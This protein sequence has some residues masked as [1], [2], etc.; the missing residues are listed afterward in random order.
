MATKIEPQNITLY[1]GQIQQFKLVSLGTHLPAWR[2]FGA[3]ATQNAD[4]SLSWVSGATLAGGGL[5]AL[6]DSGGTFSVTLTNDNFPG[7]G[8][9]GKL[10]FTALDTPN[11]YCLIEWNNSGVLTLKTKAPDYFTWYGPSGSVGLYG[12]AVTNGVE[13]SQTAPAGFTAINFNVG[14]TVT[15]DISAAGIRIIGMGSGSI[16][17]TPVSHATLGGTWLP[18]IAYSQS[19][20]LPAISSTPKLSPP[21]LTGDWAPKF[22]LGWSMD[23]AG[24][25]STTLSTNTNSVNNLT[26]NAGAFPGTYKLTVDQENA[27]GQGLDDIAATVTVPEFVVAS[28]AQIGMKK[29]EKRTIATSYDGKIEVTRTKTGGTFDGTTYTAPNA[30]GTYT[31]TFTAAGQVRTV[32]VTVSPALTPEYEIVYPG[33]VLPLTTD[34][35]GT[36]AW[37]LSAGGGALSTNS[38]TTSTWTV[39]QSQ[40]LP[41]TITLT[42]GSDTITRTYQVLDKFPYYPSEDWN[43]TRNKKTVGVTLEGGRT[44]SH[45]KSPNGL[46]GETFSFEYR[47]REIDEFEAVKTFWDKYYPDGLFMVE[48]PIRAKRYAAQFAGDLTHRMDG[49]GLIAYS[50][51][52]RVPSTATAAGNT[53][54]SAVSTGTAVSNIVNVT[55]NISGLTA[56]TGDVTASGTGSVAATLANSGVTAGNYTNASITVDGKGRVT[57][58][59]N[60]AG[61]PFAD[62]TDLIKNSADNTKLLRLSAANVTT[63]TTRTLTAQNASYT[64]AGL[65]T[66]QAFT[67]LNKFN[68]GLWA[69]NGNDNGVTIGY[70]TGIGNTASDAVRIGAFANGGA[71]TTNAQGVHVGRHSGFNQV[72]GDNSITIGH[73]ANQYGTGSS[74]SSVL[75]G[76]YAGR[77]PSQ[78]ANFY[79]FSSVMIGN[80][81][82]LNA[83]NS[84]TSVKIGA[85]AGRDATNS[86]GA[87]LIGANAGDGATN[88][89]NSVIIGNYAGRLATSAVNSV[90]IGNEAG[91]T[92][93]RNNS[94]VIDGN[95]TYSA[96]GNTGLIYGEFDNRMLKFNAATTVS[97]IGTAAKGLIVNTPSGSTETIADFTQNSVGLSVNTVSG[98]PTLIAKGADVV[99]LASRT[100]FAKPVAVGTTPA[101]DIP[102]LVDT[103]VGTNVAPYPSLIISGSNNTERLETRSYGGTSVS[104]GF[105]GRNIGGTVGSPTA[106]PSGAFLV[107]FGGTGHDGT[108]LVAGN[109]ALLAA[110]A[111]E[112]W[113]TTAQGAYFG[114]ETTAPGG[115]SRTEKLRVRGNGDVYL[116]TSS[117][118]IGIIMKSP[119]GT[120]YR[121]TVSDAGALVITSTTCP[122]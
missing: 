18:P 55:Q 109:R 7:S 90:L 22:A 99:T 57:A 112:N 16:V 62:N 29:G 120:C 54:G 114:I 56:L 46:A 108:S 93:S 4:R 15:F 52:L 23:A 20:V 40:G 113:S 72:N 122:T 79:T 71:V 19:L 24:Q 34:M 78:A 73:A 75:I 3:G 110:K 41:I 102:L 12:G 49:A 70:Q 26:I 91:R 74:A 77:N 60:G 10:Q 50:V 101:A 28:A 58:A 97:P 47:N 80:E 86:V 96:A 11:H 94:L 42:N 25:T 83:T 51:P 92:L 87:V 53:S 38:G 64:L 100:G 117:G 2:G 85:L 106:T 95:P 89:G 98:V 37:T 13:Y 104:P 68:A 31:L 1:P 66:A 32:T 39:G 82:G 69:H 67:A 105:Q 36:V 111:E 48:D 21:V 84:Q 65:E 45:V 103:S 115:V 88:A 63:G 121:L 59:S 14:E 6:G 76:A 43:A 44:V 61:N 9:T 35:S 27:G 116:P 118:S 107:F 5:Y 17:W 81:A 8:G 119:N 30:T 33:E